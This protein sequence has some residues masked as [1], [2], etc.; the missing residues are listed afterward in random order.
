MVRRAASHN[1][2]PIAL[3]P[4]DV[5]GAAADLVTPE[6]RPRLNRWQQTVVAQPFGARPPRTIDSTDNAI[7]RTPRT[8]PQQQC[9][10]QVDCGS[11]NQS[12]V[13]A[14]AT[15]A[16]AG[17][18]QG[19]RS[20]YAAGE[21]RVDLHEIW[22]NPGQGDPREATAVPVFYLCADLAHCTSSKL[23]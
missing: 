20:E 12:G 13:K 2:G 1:R 8:P 10:F 23:T 5:G 21:S 3:E 16:A 14:K 7:L 19:R 9:V 18:Q 17:N 22:R 15:A 11:C 4:S 6:S